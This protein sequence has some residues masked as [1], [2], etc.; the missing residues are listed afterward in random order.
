MKRFLVL[1]CML[2]GICSIPIHYIFAQDRNIPI[3]DSKTTD[4]AWHMRDLQ[5]K[6]EQAEQELD[7]IKKQTD[8]VMTPKDRVALAA[9][10][11]RLDMEIQRLAKEIS[12]L[13]VRQANEQRNVAK[14][15]TIT[16]YNCCNMEI[17]PKEPD[18]RPTVASY[19]CRGK[20][21]EMSASEAISRTAPEHSCPRISAA[22]GSQ[23]VKHLEVS[24]SGD[25]DR[26]AHGSNTFCIRFTNPQSGNPADPGDVSVEAT[27]STRRMNF[28]RSV[29]RVTRLSTGH[30]C[31]WVNFPVSGSWL[32][33]VK[34]KGSQGN[35]RIVFEE[36]I[37]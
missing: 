19:S 7:S 37:D 10:L 4:N 34:Y 21:K 18:G 3:I 28:V 11:Q 29:V 22:I 24:L 27:I 8:L 36:I 33:T 9:Q 31:G 6:L 26:L 2:V 1:A 23:E 25:H 12:A 32:I 5:Q 35:D 20:E 30:F 13:K 14:G 15:S 17:A 16:A